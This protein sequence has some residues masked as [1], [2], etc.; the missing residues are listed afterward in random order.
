MEVG[1]LLGNHYRLERVLG[2]GGMGVV[3][4]ARDER[5]GRAVAVKV[6]HEDPDDDPQRRK[7]FLREAWA[8][9]QL[10]H[11]YIVKVYEQ[12]DEADGASW[13]AMEYL[14]GTNLGD[15]L[16][17]GRLPLRD[18]VATL[19]PVARALG[20]AHRAGFVHRDV[21]P[22]N[23]IVCGDGRPVLVD[24]GITRTI[25]HRAPN[26]GTVDQLT[27]T[28]VLVGTPEYMSPEQVRGVVLDG[29]SDQF[30]LAVVCYEALTGV[31]PFNGDAAMAVIAAVLTDPVVPVI[32]LA[33]EVPREVSDGIARALSKK[34]DERFASIDA[35]A[36]LLDGYVPTSVQGIDLRN[37]P[38]R[39]EGASSV[40]SNTVVDIP[41]ESLREE[42]TTE[43]RGDRAS[44]APS[45]RTDETTAPTSDRPRSEERPISDDGISE[46]F[47]RTVVE[48]GDATAVVEQSLLLEASANSEETQRAPEREPPAQLDD[49][50]V[51]TVAAPRAHAKP[52]G[53]AASE[54]ATPGAA[55]A[56]PDVST[57]RFDREFLRHARREVYGPL[58]QPP[59]S[60]SR[61][62]RVAAAAAAVALI[63]L[64]GIALLA[65]R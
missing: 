65:L 13:I 19:V 15:I 18:V 44:L 2:A 7:R 46:P 56:A 26:R 9:S 34:P 35:F 63:A 53:P 54:V 20:A 23:I 50:A 30:S 6:L 43:P 58:Q 24:F 33:P 36:D 51:R 64:V 22:D 45:L 27:R 11:P 5:D 12:G 31:R 21:K 8:V 47:A 49:D 29:R 3:Y 14:D 38:R 28:G 37:L 10:S 62:R 40:G 57:E 4:L 52:V 41:T 39:G 1:R 16:E 42:P 25:S 17:R 60:R 55:R 32:D 61:G 48:M 59:G